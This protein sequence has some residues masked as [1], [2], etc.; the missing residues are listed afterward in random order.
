MSGGHK[1]GFNP[2]YVKYD[3][4]HSIADFICEFCGERSNSPIVLNYETTVQFRGQWTMTTERESLQNSIACE[5][6]GEVNENAWPRS[7][8]EVMWSKRQ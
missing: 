7:H 2:M 1:K 6:C 3:V 5:F 8:T 4:D